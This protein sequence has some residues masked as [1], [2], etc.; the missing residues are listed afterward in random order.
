MEREGISLKLSKQE[1]EEIKVKRALQ[2]EAEALGQFESKFVPAPIE[3]ENETRRTRRVSQK[4][5]SIGGRRQLT[6]FSPHTHMITFSMELDQMKTRRAKGAKIVRKEKKRVTSH[7]KILRKMTKKMILVR[8]EME[9]WR[10]TPRE[11]NL[12]SVQDV[13][14]TTFKP[15]GSSIQVA[16]PLTKK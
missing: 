6:P 5:I 13:Q 12:D 7:L 2:K 10:A 8:T 1:C 9:T 3:L 11:A 15:R 16:S 4:V 14:E